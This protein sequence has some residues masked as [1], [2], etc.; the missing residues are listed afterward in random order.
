MTASALTRLSD[1]ERA[2]NARFLPAEK[3]LEHLVTRVLVRTALGER[4]GVEPAS[5][6][7]VEGPHGRP[8]LA[9]PHTL[10]FNVTHTPGFVGVMV[11][12]TFEVGCDVEALSRAPTLLR[13]APTVFA[14]A[15]REALFAL[16]EAEQPER[17][18]RLWTLKE[19][20]IKARGL[21]LAMPLD[22]FAFRFEA[23]RLVRLEVTETWGC[24]GAQWD[25]ETT[26]LDGY[27]V[28][29]AVERGAPAVA[30]H[31]VRLSSDFA[32]RVGA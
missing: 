9:P 3:R 21:G 32:R 17:A 25:F 26:V 12:D 15:E 5:L 28:S 24:D 6:R 2:A 20:Y 8:L 14:P 19:S 23:G 4:L 29:T 22:Q 30:H 18:V 16:P 13:L 27:V 31:E 7:F 1:A 11:S 10:R